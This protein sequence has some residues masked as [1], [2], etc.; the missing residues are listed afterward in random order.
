M[1]VRVCSSPAQQR[2]RGASWWAD[3]ACGPVGWV[4]TFVTNTTAPLCSE[5]TTKENQ[6]A[7]HSG[8]LQLVGAGRKVGDGRLNV[9]ELDPESSPQAA[10]GAKVRSR[11]EERGWRQED[12]AAR[13][14]YSS[15][16]I[17]SIETGRKLPTL[18]FSRSADLAFGS[19]DVF[20]GQWRALR[21]GSLLE[22]FPHREAIGNEEL[23][24][25]DVDV[26]VPAALENVITARNAHRLEGF[27]SDLF[28]WSVNGNSPFH[29]RQIDTGSEAGI[30]GGIAES[31]GSWPNAATGPAA[32]LPAN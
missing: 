12:L 22:G 19:G 10:F 15:T 11:R 7:S 2:S 5:T 6:R 32:R 17:S 21:Y 16:H 3:A 8:S 23:L 18:R 4:G 14:E 13:M 25:L 26:L 27:Y 9:K 31:G 20:E 24:E 30:Q 1:T 28:D 29:Y